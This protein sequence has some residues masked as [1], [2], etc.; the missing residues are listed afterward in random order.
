MSIFSS[1][2]VFRALRFCFLL[3]H[4]LKKE[5]E[6]KKQQKLISDKNRLFNLI[7]RCHSP[8]KQGGACTQRRYAIYRVSFSDKMRFFIETKGKTQKN[9]VFSYKKMSEQQKFELH[10]VYRSSLCSLW[11]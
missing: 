11:L 9:D 4:K 8:L 10:H 2:T 5:R 6:K 1:F 7:N 3:K